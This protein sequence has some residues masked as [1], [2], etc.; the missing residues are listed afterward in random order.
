LAIWDGK[1]AMASS[2][3]VIRT[4]VPPRRRRRWLVIWL[5]IDLIAAILIITL[6]LHRPAAYKPVLQT[7]EANDPDR[8][9]SYL[10]H[11]SS[12]LYNGA[13]TQAP[14]DLVVLEEGINRAIGPHS[15]SDPAAETTFAS[16]QVMFRPQGL[17]LMGR[18]QLKG[19][20]FVVTV[21]VKPRIDD[22]GLLT[23]D[24]ASVKVG[25]LGLTTLARVMAHR[26]YSQRLAEGPVDTEDI[27]PQIAAALL[28]GQ[29]LEPV[30]TVRNR[31]VRLKSVDLQRGQVVLRFVPAQAV[32]QSKNTGATGL[33]PW[34]LL[35]CTKGGLTSSYA[36]L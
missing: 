32:P 36:R 14:F 27:R 18:A 26:M 1:D 35:P 4:Y 29:P 2:T 19:A 11:L 16:P 17:T 7:A 10:T 22:Q 25:A 8:V 15:W 5:G 30:L 31:K 34:P 21:G 12:D 3:E 23:L 13:Q 6:L 24:V 9:D 33:L 28:N 20:S